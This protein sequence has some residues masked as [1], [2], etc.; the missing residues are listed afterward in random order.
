M[1]RFLTPFYLPETN[2][3]RHATSGHAMKMLPLIGLIACRTTPKDLPLNEGSVND[4]AASS[5]TESPTATGATDND[6]SPTD[7]V[8]P[9]QTQTTAPHQPTPKIKLRPDSPTPDDTDTDTDKSNEAS[10]EPI[11]IQL[12]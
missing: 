4:T 11:R 3:N 7:L 12:T 8:T 5:Q 6:A 1:E 2:S 9:T 10:D